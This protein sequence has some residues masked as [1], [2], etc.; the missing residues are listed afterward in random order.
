MKDWLH[1]PYFWV[2]TALMA[3]LQFTRY[4]DGQTDLVRLIVAVQLG[5]LLWGVI[6]TLV[7][8]RFKK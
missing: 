8:K 6:A 3:I 2:A 1:L 7:A 5:G 4:M